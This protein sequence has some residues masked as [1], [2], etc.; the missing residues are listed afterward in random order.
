MIHGDRPDEPRAEII[1]VTGEPL[2]PARS[3]PADDPDLAPDPA[4]GRALAPIGQRSSRALGATVAIVA[5]LGL[6][7]FAGFA[8]RGQVHPP[9][10][11][12]SAASGLTS[13]DQVF[14]AVA[15]GL[16][17]V[18]V[19]AAQATAA[20]PA[21]INAEVAV[22]GWYSAIRL[23]ESCQP[24]DQPLGSCVSDG[25]AVLESRPDIRWSSDGASHPI[26]P[27][28]TSISPLFIDPI[29]PPQF[30]SGNPSG[31]LEIVP[32]SPL[33]LIGHFHDDRL[34]AQ[35]TGPTTACPAFVV[36]ALA[37]LSGTVS[38]APGPLGVTTT[39]LTSAT[40]VGLITTRLQPTGHPFG[41]G[42]LPWSVDLSAPPYVEPSGAGPPID[43]RTV[44]LVRGYTD[45]DAGS[46]IASWMA[47]DDVTGQVWG[48]LAQAV[49]AAPLGPAF[50]A[51]VDG[52]PVQTVAAAL[53][54]G[55]GTHAVVAVAGYLSSDRAVEGCPPAPTT[56]KP[57]PCSGTQLVVVDRPAVVLQPNDATFLYDIVV[58]PQLASIRP[59]ILP[60]TSVADPW[61]AATN[62]DDRL[63]PRP[64]VLIGQFADPRS[65]DCAPRPGGG[66][67]GCD[68][69]FLV[70]QLAWLDGSLQGP[71]V[72]IGPN[73][74]PSHSVEDATKAVA[75]WFL[76]RS[77]PAIVSLTSTLPADSANLTGVALDGRLTQRSWVV[78]VI[79]NLPDGPVSSLLVFDDRTLDLIEVTAGD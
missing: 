52:L 32:P 44:W 61:A 40:V 57:N 79:T 21:A 46:A 54:S 8:N 59:V 68:R 51:T 39:R 22:G 49:A 28:T 33:V 38:L 4:P 31:P 35:A 78:R 63:A 27:G 64:V 77:Q 18:S 56:D 6:V 45:T 55:P 5:A 70:D 3:R 20:D 60:G 14:P 74:Q 48:P 73:A 30:V 72:F 67:A 16:P 36:D 7:A 11:S 23:A 65:P 25:Q 62:L 69:S 66:N 42:A 29:A 50:P 10:P 75:G 76:P 2:R 19:A 41:F 9:G 15:G 1:D 26:Q 13:D 12:G 58:P 53:P 17:V 34:C 24:S 71:S 37:D 43:G 47:I